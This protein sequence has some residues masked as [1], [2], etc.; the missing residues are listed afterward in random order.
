L[1]ADTAVAVRKESFIA[2]SVNSS[3]A[4]QE[5]SKLCVDATN[6][7][8]LSDSMAKALT[9]SLPALVLLAEHAL[10]ELSASEWCHVIRN[11]VGRHGYLTAAD[12]ARL[13]NGG[14]D[15]TSARRR[16]FR[17]AA[18]TLC[19]ECCVGLARRQPQM[20]EWC[21]AMAPLIDLVTG[22]LSFADAEGDRRLELSLAVIEMSEAVLL[23][24]PLVPSANLLTVSH[25]VMQLATVCSQIDTSATVPKRLLVSLSTRVEDLQRA[26]SPSEAVTIIEQSEKLAVTTDESFDATRVVLRQVASNG[27]TRAAI[28]D[29]I[30]IVRFAVK[31]GDGNLAA[32]SAIR[33][34]AIAACD[35]VTSLS[36][37]QRRAEW[38]CVLALRH[39][40][41]LLQ[42]DCGDTLPL[43]DEQRLAIANA[44]A[45]S[46]EYLL[47]PGGANFY[48]MAQ[49]L[50]HSSDVSTAG[51][52]VDTASDPVLSLTAADRKAM[53]ARLLSPQVVAACGAHE[54]L[55]FMANLL[56]TAFKRPAVDS[57]DEDTTLAV[58]STRSR[59]DD[60][61]ESAVVLLPHVASLM[62]ASGRCV[63]TSPRP[64]NAY[65]TG[66]F[67]HLLQ[68]L[69]LHAKSI[70]DADV[71]GTAW[72]G[73]FRS[74]LSASPLFDTAALEHVHVVLPLM[75]LRDLGAVRG[76]LRPAR[77]PA[78]HDA[79]RD[80]ETVSAVSFWSPEGSSFAAAVVDA[81][82][83]ALLEI[84]STET[85]AEGTPP[86]R[87]LSEQDER[88]ITQL[89]ANVATGAA[90]RAVRESSDENVELRWK[91]KTVSICTATLSWAASQHRELHR[92]STVLQIL[93]SVS[94]I[95]YHVAEADIG[96]ADVSS[97]L[98]SILLNALHRLEVVVALPSNDIHG[99]HTSQVLRCLHFSTS[100]SQLIKKGTVAAQ[101]V[102]SD[103]VDIASHL[104]IAH[105]AVY[106]A[107][108][109]T[110]EQRNLSPLEASLL[111][112]AMSK[113][114]ILSSPVT[115]L[116]IPKILDDESASTSLDDDA[117]NIRRIVSTLTALRNQRCDDIAARVE[118][119]TMR[120]VSTAASAVACGEAL[121]LTL[122]DVGLVAQNIDITGSNIAFAESLWC[123]GS[124]VLSTTRDDPGMG[125]DEVLKATTSL[126]RSVLE[127]S[128]VSRLISA[129]GVSASQRMTLLACE[130]L[131][132]AM[133]GDE[134]FNEAVRCIRAHGLVP[135]VADFLQA[136]TRTLSPSVATEGVAEGAS[137]VVRSVTAMCWRAV[138][139]SL[140]MQQSNLLKKRVPPWFSMAAHRR[141]ALLD[142]LVQSL[143]RAECHREE[144][145]CVGD[146]AL[147]SALLSAV[148]AAPDDHT[149]MS[150]LLSQS[151]LA[152]VA[153]HVVDVA[154]AATAR[155]AGSVAL[156]A[157]HLLAFAERVENVLQLSAPP[158]TAAAEPVLRQ[159]LTRVAC[160]LRTT[161]APSA[162]RMLSET[163]A[164]NS[165]TDVDATVATATVV[166]L[167]LLVTTTVDTR[168]AFHGDRLV[169]TVKLLRHLDQ[170]IVAHCMQ[171][172]D[173][174]VLDTSPD[175]KILIGSQRVSVDT[176]R[177]GSRYRDAR[178][179]S[180]ADVC[181]RFTSAVAK[182]SETSS[183]SDRGE[184]D[185]KALAARQLDALSNSS[186]EL[187]VIGT[188][189]VSAMARLATEC[190]ERGSR[191]LRSAT[192]SQLLQVVTALDETT[193]A[194]LPL[195][196]ARL[197]SRVAAFGPAS[198]T[199]ADRNAINDNL[200]RLNVK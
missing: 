79:D 3:M 157:K 114:R 54:A 106:L 152:A 18:I 45:S 146:A 23:L 44:L 36:S 57:T 8:H 118:E 48:T 38:K 197:R 198:M 155:G 60:L 65:E 28:A 105:K 26:L 41:S 20:R 87:P 123:V 148:V 2:L 144:I 122:K 37:Q 81:V 140:A 158:G 171:S 46:T 185:A 124:S 30:S 24:V 167:L 74:A 21:S 128:H 86:S 51:R 177:L 59:F 115:N 49:A 16:E 110:L 175:R 191:A 200:S 15:A 4:V 71:L 181:E 68:R 164:L 19:T 100:I 112:A 196:C 70:N 129:D 9:E 187:D 168:R 161:A 97:L 5:L 67:F 159:I 102:H 53:V 154:A 193:V 179:P 163:I 188:A 42:L 131:A 141:L 33:L 166:R 92:G 91:E 98:Q 109:A 1:L 180:A 66:V 150:E 43:T 50:L 61:R 56:N 162:E 94:G 64:P 125:F 27:V 135:E 151:D 149:D 156:T 143:G 130:R 6:A 145:L 35:E 176:A 195:V 138:I 139:A 121:V 184:H 89:V 52:G 190:D 95:A 77:S 173:I 12:L 189:A 25:F 119:R 29:L 101:P 85:N 31:S 160:A 62:V 107:F 116:L 63:A 108:A 182:I 84:L 117:K 73:A 69:H 136:V 133:E 90:P 34:A 17:A 186:T 99:L 82:D 58:R 10:C 7:E 134:R 165:S 22:A 142:S 80:D 113:A 47:R 172:G 183:S 103:Q 72:V 194:L 132:A 39:E 153:R 76:A 96:K 174:P 14:V 93:K 169:S 75:N 120:V 78:Q 104:F 126:M 55:P 199:V 137:A 11:V 127:A 192:A 32:A 178:W 147:I 13:P 83:M 170:V 88:R 111:V 40:F